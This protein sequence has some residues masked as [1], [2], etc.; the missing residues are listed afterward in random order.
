MRNNE[1]PH[2]IVIA[3][4]PYPRYLNSDWILHTYISEHKEPFRWKKKVDFFEPFDYGLVFSTYQ[5]ALSAADKINKVIRDA[6]NQLDAPQEIKNSYFLRAEKA[7]MSRGR[8]KNEEDLMLNE[9]LRI[10]SSLPRPEDSE[11]IIKINAYRR[12]DISIKDELLKE[13]KLNPLIE[14]AHLKENRMVIGKDEKGEWGRYL[15]YN[16]RT[17]QVAFR[18]KISRSFGFSGRDHWGKVKSEIRLRLLPRANELLQLAS[19]KRMLAEAYSQGHKVLMAGGYVF[20]YEENGDIGWTVKTTNSNESI[21]NGESI[22]H[23]GTIIS[24]NHGRIVVFPYIKENGEKV[25]GHTKNAPHD[26]KAKPR[27]PSEYVELPFHIL[28]DDL[29]IGLFGE[30]K[31]E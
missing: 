29:M 9:A 6:I 22:W 19:V 3:V 16:E 27:H 30:L 20:W 23:D 8:L 1:Y 15:Y 2:G 10:T 31:Y 4:H 11:V 21:K 18:E 13:I 7:I 12:A 17:T 25:Q 24:K 5:E 28:E 14:I 26:G